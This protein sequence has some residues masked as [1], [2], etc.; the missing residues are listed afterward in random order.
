MVWE[1]GGSSCCCKCS[2]NTRGQ[3][4]LIPNGRRQGWQL[5]APKGAGSL[6]TL[7]RPEPPALSFGITVEIPLPDGSATRLIRAA[8]IKIYF[9]VTECSFPT[10]V[11]VNPRHILHKKLF[12]YSDLTD[13]LG[14]WAGKAVLEYQGDLLPT[15][16]ARACQQTCSLV[17]HES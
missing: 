4:N 5:S 9:K 8:K 15:W 3:N 2:H 1:G 11:A 13:L 7:P 10:Q 6:L 17:R 16:P 14:V 12:A